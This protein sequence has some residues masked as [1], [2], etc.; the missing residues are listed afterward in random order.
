M[1]T[2]TINVLEDN[3]GAVYLA[4]TGE[5]W[6]LGPVTAD[7]K[8]QAVAHASAWASGEWEPNETDG[9]VPA[10]V[11]DL[12][13]IGQWTAAG[14]LVVTRDVWGEPVAGFGGREYLGVRD[15]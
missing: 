3:A 5:V 15:E 1:H 14:G 10:G 4:A 8:E 7:M 12:E 11:D 13:L 6:G 2:E 9:Q